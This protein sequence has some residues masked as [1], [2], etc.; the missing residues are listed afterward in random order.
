MQKRRGGSWK[1]NIIVIL[2]GIAFILVFVIARFS[3]RVIPNT[4]GEFISAI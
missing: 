3:G 2:I 1:T 4:E